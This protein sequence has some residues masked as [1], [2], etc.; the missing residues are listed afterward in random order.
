MKKIIQAL[1]FISVICVLQGCGNILHDGTSMQIARV[2]VDVTQ[3]AK[4]SNEHADGKEMQFGY[5]IGGV[6]Y[7]SVAKGAPVTTIEDGKLIYIFNPPLVVNSTEFTVLVGYWFV[8]T[9]PDSKIGESVNGNDARIPNAWS[10]NVDRTL[11]AVV[12]DYA[13]TWE[14]ID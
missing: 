11:K 9:W 2:E 3:S 1:I 5:T 10:G 8:G 4:R 6:W 12:K 13:V 7:D 14:I